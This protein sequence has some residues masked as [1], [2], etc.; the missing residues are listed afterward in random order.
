[1]SEFK[2][3]AESIKKTFKI[4]NNG[5]SR[6]N[7]NSSKELIA[8]EDINLNVKKNEFLVQADVENQHFLI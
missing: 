8:L 2:I 1:M 6:N 4:R 7:S 3:R 5:N